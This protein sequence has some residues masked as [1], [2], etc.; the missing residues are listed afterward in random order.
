M[1]TSITANSGMKPRTEKKEGA[2][3]RT[4]S[5]RFRYL[6]LSKDKKMRSREGMKIRLKIANIA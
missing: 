6:S 5:V 3:I 2:K 4:A 1:H